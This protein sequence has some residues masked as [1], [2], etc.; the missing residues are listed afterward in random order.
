MAR[1]KPKKAPAKQRIAEAAFN[2]FHLQGVTAT[3]VDQILSDAEAGKGQFYYYF[4]NKTDLVHYVLE[5]AYK[6]LSET[7][8]GEV[9]AIKSMKDLKNL[10]RILI[11]I[12][13]ETEFERSC[14]IATIGMDIDSGQEQLREDTKKI[15][16][17]LRSQ[18]A[19]FF[20]TLRS[21]GKISK[22]QNPDKLANFCITAL[23]GG[24]LM[25]K[26]HRDSEM[27]EDTAEQVLKH[28]RSI[29]K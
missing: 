13:K 27:F 17:F 24:L 12:Q 8:T 10:F 18:V 7:E 1:A 25:S 28:I 9:Y 5:Q 16:S 6:N 3:G 15:F 2:L 19:S 11:D 22:S 14:P 21:T 23:Q 4:K 26:I 20:H 29:L